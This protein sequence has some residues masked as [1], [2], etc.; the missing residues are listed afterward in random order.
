MPAAAIASASPSFWL[1]MP[2]AP[3]RHLPV[4]DRRGLVR[5]GV[6]A[7]GDVEP[8]ARLLQLGDVASEAV[9]IDGQG[10]GCPGR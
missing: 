9:E 7:Q 6:H 10:G 3:G 8:V 2:I 4:G 1:T 5:L